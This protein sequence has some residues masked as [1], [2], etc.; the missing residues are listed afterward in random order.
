M[1]PTPERPYFGIF[2]AR[3]VEALRRLGVDVSVEPVAGGRG[4]QDYFLARPRIRRAVRQ[5]QPDIVHCHY[6]YTALAAPSSDVPVVL[7]LCGDDLNGASNGRGG[8]TLKSRAGVLVTQLGARGAAR[9]IVKSDAMRR[10]LWPAARRKSALLPNGVST[11]LFRP[12]SRAA[13]RARLGVADD[14]LV[15]GFV[16]SIGQPTKRLDLAQATCDV[17]VARGVSARLLVAERVAPAEMVWHY[18]AADCL[19][20]TSEREGAPNCVKEALACGVP[21]VGVPVG[22]LPEL[23]TRPEMG[24]IVPPD[25][26]RL[27]DAVMALDPR[28]DVPASLLPAH[29]TDESV[30]E[31]LIALYRD[32][33]S[34]RAGQAGAGTA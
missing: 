30:A 10:R 16:N 11:E 32:V 21:V 24:R 23:L 17:L 15:L 6:G 29:L 26:E 31:R 1:Y 18:R 25:P 9:V 27:A 13:A 22:D 4:E 8:V 28:P 33:L 3:Q 19:L 20:M 14:A 2:V 5:F 7:T 12:G 34:S